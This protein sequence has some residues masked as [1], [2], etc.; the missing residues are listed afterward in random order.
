MAPKAKILEAEEKIKQQTQKNVF[1]GVVKRRNATRSI[2]DALQGFS[3]PDEIQVLANKEL[4][5]ASVAVWR[6]WALT[7]VRHRRE[8][9]ALR[10]SN[11]KQIAKYLDK[12]QKHMEKAQARIDLRRLVKQ[13][14]AERGPLKLAESLPPC[15]SPRKMLS[16]LFD[17]SVISSPYLSPT[18]VC[19]PGPLSARES[20]N[21]L[22]PLLPGSRSIMSKAA[23]TRSVSA[24]HARSKTNSASPVALHS[25]SPR[26]PQKPR[27]RISATPEFDSDED[28]S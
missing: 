25:F 11:Q 12:K 26:P 21:R 24:D 7:T 17:E 4:L 19:K 16:D 27:V 2:V 14:L 5:E 10:A 15:P 1:Y 18:P 20:S 22:P 28:L 13:N 3:T 6:R 23:S 8:E 9:E